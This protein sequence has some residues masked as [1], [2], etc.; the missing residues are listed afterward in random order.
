MKDQFSGSPNEDPVSHLNTIVELCD[1]Q[2]K[3]DMDNDIMKLQLFPFS[4]RDKAKAWFSSLPPNS[5]GTWDKCKYAFIAKYFPPA[6]IISLRNQILNFKQHDQERC[7]SL[8]VNEIDDY[9]LP[10]K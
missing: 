3:K 10:C 2:N 8:G 7:T 5:I 6:K 4:I 9:K 1:M